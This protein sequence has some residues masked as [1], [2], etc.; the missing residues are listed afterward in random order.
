MI[1][2]KHTIR[3]S[4]EI[5]KNCPGME[6]KQCRMELTDNWRDIFMKKPKVSKAVEGET[7]LY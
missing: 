2:T 5:T 7:D 1:E 4:K 6:K 3:V